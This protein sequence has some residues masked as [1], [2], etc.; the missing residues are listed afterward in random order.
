MVTAYDLNGEYRLERILVAGKPVE[1]V[2]GHLILSAMDESH[3]NFVSSSTSQHGDQEESGSFSVEGN[4]LLMAVLEST[5]PS[6]VGTVLNLRCQ[7]EGHKL[8]LEHI[9]VVGREGDLVQH[10]R[11][12]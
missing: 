10:W 8:Q 5:M 12:V 9:D 4:M 3:G 7:L 11:R 1:D 6:M 2:E